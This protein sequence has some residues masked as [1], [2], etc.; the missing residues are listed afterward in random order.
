MQKIA[1]FFPCYLEL[2]MK[3]KEPEKKNKKKMQKNYF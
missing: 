3:K 2:K 1:H